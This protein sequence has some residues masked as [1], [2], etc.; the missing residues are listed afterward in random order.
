MGEPAVFVEGVS[1][2]YQLSP[3]PPSDLKQWFLRFGRVA[4]E[5]FW[6]LRDVSL[7]VPKGSTFG[8]IG[9]NGS[10]KSTLLRLIA[11]IHRPTTGT[12]T[13]NGRLAALLA[14]GAGFHPELTGR[15]N[16][17]LNGSILGMTRRE[18]RAKIGEIVEFA[19]LE[20]FIDVPVKVYSSGMFVRLGFAVAVHLD[21]EILIIDE[22]IAVGDAEFQRR[23]FDHMYEMRRRTGLTILV[24]S[25]GHGLLQQMCDEVGWLDHGCLLQ[26]GE[27]KDVIF[28]YLQNVNRVEAERFAAHTRKQQ[29]RHQNDDRAGDV[30]LMP[31]QRASVSMPEHD[32]RR[33][34]TRDVEILQ[35]TYWDGL[36][37]RLEAASSGGPL[38]IRITYLA[39]SAIDN[40][41]CSL[42]I[43]TDAGVLVTEMSNRLAGVETGHVEGRC[44]ID[45][46]IERLTLLPG[47]YRLSVSLFDERG[48]HAF[49]VRDQSF[50]LHVQPGSGAE[51]EGLVDLQGNWVAGEPRAIPPRP[52]PHEPAAGV[53]A[54]PPNVAPSP[55]VGGDRK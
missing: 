20:D 3:D 24:V 31:E 47:T 42:Q 26:T 13:T 35:V 8:L 29:V 11:G 36:G 6:A 49:D 53:A 22:V 52:A 1:K 23:C 21:P 51:P 41:V 19:G 44:Y 48:L 14:L 45:Y 27:P 7:T 32:D 15:E 28:S 5:E 43:E 9:H 12:I 37:N 38:V 4:Y 10:G 46:R 34:G 55:S 50:V 30:P 17:F 39:H 18:I 40:A 2:R 16:V 33:H 25:H 54:T